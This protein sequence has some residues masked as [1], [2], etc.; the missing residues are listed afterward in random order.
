VLTSSR[1][2]EKWLNRGLWVISIIF[3][4]FLIGLGSLV[5]EDLPKVQTSPRM[6]DY[7][8]KTKHDDVV[9]TIAAKESALIIRRK[10]RDA[11]AQKVGQLNTNYYK[12]KDVFN[13]WIATRQSTQDSSQNGEVLKRTKDLELQQSTIKTEDQKLQLKDEEIKALEGDLQADQSRKSDLEK[14]AY[15]KVETALRRNQLQ[16][17]L[18]RLAIT[19]PLLLIGAW[20][21][22][23]KRKSRQ[24]PFV[25]GFVF[26]SLY[27]FFVEL[28][29]YLPSYGG[30]VR[31]IVGIIVTYFVGHYSIKAL[32]SYLEKQAKAEAQPNTITK[33]KI[34]Y[35]L[36]QQR[37]SKGICPGCERPVDLKDPSK[38][39]CI[40][41][42]TCLFN[43]CVK[44]KA[45]KNAFAK[46]CH[47]CGEAG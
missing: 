45:R 36:S 31:Y 24:W 9:K 16:V 11:D 29:P 4:G 34:D 22:I 8:D 32:Q 27:A 14:T 20:L 40:H 19:L 43:D 41:C 10:D 35:D 33:E 30:Y 6:E 5:V 3:A 47:A 1:L 2:T 38:N 18:Y 44:C 15:E 42:G 13:N 12:S 46:Y 26:F 23:K 21:F 39:F 7:V 17:F 37:L 25:W 28:V